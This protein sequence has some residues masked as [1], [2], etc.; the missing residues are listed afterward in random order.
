MS[1]PIFSHRLDRLLTGFAV[2]RKI[3]SF[4][5]QQY[6]AD[7]ATNSK[8]RPCSAYTILKV[9]IAIMKQLFLLLLTIGF[10]SAKAQIPE[11]IYVSNTNSFRTNY[12]LEVDKDSV[13]LLGWETAIAEDTIYFKSTSKK[14]RN[15]RF[16]FTEFRFSKSKINLNSFKTFAD[17]SNIKPDTFLLHRYLFNFEVMGN[18]ISL[19][20]TKDYYLNRADTFEFVK[21]D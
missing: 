2:I 3:R 12:F 4:N 14:D 16:I 11:G 15:D 9:A 19:L 17:E 7:T 8:L 5:V 10:I 6:Q 21:T 18:L 1:L 13:S 20:A